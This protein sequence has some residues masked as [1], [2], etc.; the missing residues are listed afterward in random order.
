MN[1]SRFDHRGYRACRAD[2]TRAVPRLW[3]TW[4]AI[5]AWA[6]TSAA[7]GLALAWSMRG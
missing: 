6:L 2:R 4:R 7:L 3:A 5:L 1:G